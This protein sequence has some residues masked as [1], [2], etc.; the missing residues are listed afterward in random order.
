MIARHHGQRNA[1]SKARRNGSHGPSSRSGSGT[2]G[3]TKHP[4][5]SH[6]GKPVTQSLPSGQAGPGV[7]GAQ[8][9]SAGSTPNGPPA[10]SNAGGNGNGN[11]GGSQANSGS[12]T[13]WEHSAHGGQGVGNGGDPPGAAPA[14]SNAGG[15]GNGNGPPAHSNAG[16]N[17][18]G[19][20]P[21]ADAAAQ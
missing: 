12:H 18:K 6:G 21:S 16:G 11:G 20:S 8:A 1:A 7:P 13:G 14:T 4:S 2:R 9:P 3:T 5:T 15:N 19:N 17:G 10:T